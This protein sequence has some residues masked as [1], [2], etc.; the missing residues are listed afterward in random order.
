ML[1]GAGACGLFFFGDFDAAAFLGA[2]EVV[3][4]CSGVAA[5]VGGA[6]GGHVGGP[7]GH[8]VVAEGG[9]LAS[10]DDDAGAGEAEAGGGDDLHELTVGEVAIGVGGVLVVACVGAHAGE[11]DGELG[12]PAML[13]EVFEVGGEGEG[14]GAPVGEAK[15]GADADAAEA[16]AIG[17]LGALEPPVEVLL[18]AGGVKGLVGVAVVGLLVDDEAFGS[19]FDELGVLMVFHG[20][21]F[22]AD[23]G[24]EG[25]E[26]ANDVLEV[27]V[28]DELGVFAGDEEEVAEPLGVQVASFLEDLLGGEGG[29]QDGVVARESAVGAVV[30]TLVGHVKRGEESDCFSEVSARDLCGLAGER[31]EL[32]VVGGRDEVFETTQKG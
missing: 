15:E 25:G 27:A 9:R 12:L 6:A 10:G 3:A 22:D 5:G 8:E 28:G 29:A 2:V 17:A 4:A 30:N 20:A 18:G 14:L 11:G 24:E 26:L 1:G 21:D 31:L 13:V 23:G 16:S 19:G 32:S 7:E